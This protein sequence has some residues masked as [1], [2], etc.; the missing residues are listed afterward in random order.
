MCLFTYDKIVSVSVPQHLQAMLLSAFPERES[1]TKQTEV[2]VQLRNVTYVNS[3]KQLC[4]SSIYA[5][6]AD[7]VAGYARVASST[8]IRPAL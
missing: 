1:Q 7:A 2:S 8:D 6:A 4:C 5:A 3:Y